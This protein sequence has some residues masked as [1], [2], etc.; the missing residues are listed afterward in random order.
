[1]RAFL[2]FRAA[3][4]AW[5][6]AAFRFGLIQLLIRDTRTPRVVP[7]SNSHGEFA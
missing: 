6:T 7:N 4:R 1:M 2:S 3:T 5:D